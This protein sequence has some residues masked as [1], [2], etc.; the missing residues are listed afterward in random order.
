M[1]KRCYVLV[2]ASLLVVAGNVQAEE[3]TKAEDK[4]PWTSS[5][6]L[7]FIRTTGNTKTQTLAGKADVVYEVEKWR[8]TGHAEGYG[9]EAENQTTGENEVS[10][11]RY[12][13]VGKSDYKFTE[14]DYV[15]GL[16]KLQ[17]D[18]FS[19]FE[20]DHIISAGYGR[21]AIKQDNMELDLE[22][23]PG[24]RFF[25]VDDG[26]AKE[27]AVLRLAAKYWWQITDASKFTQ[28]LST[29]IGEEITTSESITG[30]QASI[31]KTL[32][33]KFT[34]TVR[35]KTKVPADN[36]KTDTETAMTLVYTF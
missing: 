7:G 19:G 9:A 22:I 30:I 25:K 28:L 18:R 16:V 34:Y 35:H 17:K 23:G 6:E 5:V 12:Q 3:E 2:L 11:E 36:E 20:Y 24:E 4:S 26:Q 33:L 8:H 1:K 32:A 31:N 15:F 13:L 27:E 14:R 29:E 21:K 10:A